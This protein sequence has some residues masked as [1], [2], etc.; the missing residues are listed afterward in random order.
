MPVKNAGAYLH[1]CLSSIRGQTFS[2]WELIVVND[3]S[4]DNSLKILEQHAAEDPR[5]R[6]FQNPGQGIIPA[7]QC[8][9]ANTRGTYI[10]RMDGDDLMP[11]NRLELMYRA[12]ENQP[13]KTIITGKVR[14]FSNTEV[15]EGYQKYEQW[16]NERV[17]QNDHWSWI[18]RE[19]V[20]AS[21][22]WMV[23]KK[24]LLAMKAFEQLSYPEDYDLVL[25]WY[26]HGFEVHC[27][28]ELTLHWREHPARTSRNSE[29]YDQAHFFRLKLRHFLEQEIRADESLVLWGVNPKGRVTAQILQSYDQAFTWMDLHPDQYPDGV[30]GQSILP[31]QAIETISGYKLLIAV[32]PPEKERRKLEVYLQGL[33]LQMGQDY[34]YL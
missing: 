11:E 16:L 10:T 4:T 6:R 31:F 18:Y 14:Y 19:C 2:F 17:T 13:D 20:I 1:D 30:R 24:D 32:Y 26:R 15:S 28:N 8:A 33:G 27:L 12:I 25:K 3:H 9:L 34:W 5:I 22:N 7:L 23:R 29:H 21:P